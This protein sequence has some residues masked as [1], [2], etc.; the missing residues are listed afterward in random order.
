MQL[1]ER[2]IN[3]LKALKF[4][5]R[6]VYHVNNDPLIF[7]Q[8]PDFVEYARQNLPNA[9][10]HIL[11]NGKTLTLRKAESLLRAG[12]NELS[13]NYYNDDFSAELPKTIQNIRDELLP[14]FYKPEQIRPRHGPRD[15]GSKDIFTF[16]V[17]RRKATEILTSRAGTSPNKKEKSKSPRGFCEY[18]F[19]QF[20]ITA[21]GRVSKCCADFYFSDPMGNVNERSVID[22]WTGEKFNNVRRSLLQGNRDAIE[23]CKKCDFYGVQKLH[24]NI[25]RFLYIITQ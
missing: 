19:T 10:I 7:P 8:L 2:V 6:I 23:S 3:E 17:F 20:N 21:D 14:K 13:I 1:H 11:T 24:S 25:G 22:I 4:S 18:P 12:I 5:G 15:Y 9:W 16:N